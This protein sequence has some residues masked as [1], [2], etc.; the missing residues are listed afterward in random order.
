MTTIP[1]PALADV[2]LLARRLHPTDQSRLVAHLAPAIAA[3]LDE[4]TTPSASAEDPRA[5]LAQLR[6]AF[7]AEGP[8]A[9]SIT[10]ELLASRR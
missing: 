7:R 3:A 4:A 8:I 9:P 5:T 2:L 10:D 1:R 6:E